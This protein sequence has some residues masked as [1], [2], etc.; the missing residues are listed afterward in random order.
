MERFYANI[1]NKNL[2]E[3]PF[4]DEVFGD[5]YAAPD[6]RKNGVRHLVGIVGEAYV[7]ASWIFGSHQVLIKVIAVNPF[8][9]FDEVRSDVFNLYK[10]IFSSWQCEDNPDLVVEFSNSGKNL[11][12]NFFFDV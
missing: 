9:D 4:E 12:V 8:E 10:K 6:H 2:M 11:V 5:F 7:D 3:D 1:D